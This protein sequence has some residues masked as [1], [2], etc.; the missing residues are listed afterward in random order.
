LLPFQGVKLLEA[1]HENSITGVTVAALI[2][3]A[4][5]EGVN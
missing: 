4:T 3:P 5:F 2:L 1:L